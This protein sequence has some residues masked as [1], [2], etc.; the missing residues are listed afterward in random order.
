MN[1]AEHKVTLNLSEHDAL[2]LLTLIRKKIDQEEKIWQ[3]Y[4]ERLAQCVENS[5]EQASFGRFKLDD[6]SQD[7]FDKL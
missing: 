1:T 6:H 7:W 5:I 3:P 4:W 2:K